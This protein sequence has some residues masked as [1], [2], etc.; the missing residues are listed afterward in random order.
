MVFA[1]ITGCVWAIF[2]LAEMVIWF[3]GRGLTYALIDAARPAFNLIAIVAILSAGARASRGRSSGRRSA[4][5]SA[6]VICVALIWKSF[7]LGFSFSE[8]KEILKRGAI[9]APIASSMWVVQNADS[10]ILSRFV[11]HKDDRPLQLASRTGFMVAFLPQGFRMALRPVRKTAVYG[12][13]CDEYGMAVANGQLLAYFWLITLTAVLAMVLGGEILIQIG[14]PRFESAAP[15]DPA[16][17][18]RDVDAGAVPERQP[19]RESIRTSAATSS[20][21]RSWWRSPTSGSC[22][23]C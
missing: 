10:F 3:E 19:V 12:R 21:R 22:C 13:S 17:R 23:C 16:D 4:P 7:Q 15:I 1:T 9:R 20:S 2:K 11:D 5:R 18:G 8:L 6:T 14:G